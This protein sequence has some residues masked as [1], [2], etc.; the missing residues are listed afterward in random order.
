VEAGLVPTYPLRTRTHAHLDVS[1]QRPLGDLIDTLLP[2]LLLLL[3]DE[4]LGCGQ[5]ECKGGWSSVR[6]RAGQLRKQ[7]HIPCKHLESC[8]G[9]TT[10]D[11]CFGS[12]ARLPPSP[13]IC[14]E[15]SWRCMASAAISWLSCT[16]A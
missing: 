6:V 11:S 13:A 15:F 3:L 7:G 10:G 2:L 5:D 4:Q 1:R 14:S 16:S 9:G 8:Q 12:A